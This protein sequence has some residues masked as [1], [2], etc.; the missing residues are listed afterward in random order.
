VVDDE[1]VT[2]P[3]APLLKATVLLAAVK[4]NPVPTIVIALELIARLV[5]LN[6]TVGAATMLAT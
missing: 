4:E 3:T 6:V 2:V 5:V 1:L